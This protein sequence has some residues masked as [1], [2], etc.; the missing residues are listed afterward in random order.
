MKRY[1]LLIILLVSCTSYNDDYEAETIMK[2]KNIQPFKSPVKPDSRNE[3]LKYCSQ[4][5]SARKRMDSLAK[6]PFSLV[7]II[8]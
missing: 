5:E 1:I 4:A 3:K 6:K 2:Y 7:T 8:C